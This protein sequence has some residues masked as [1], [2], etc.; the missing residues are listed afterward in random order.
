M[1]KR[2]CVNCESEDVDYSSK[3]VNGNWF[4]CASCGWGFPETDAAKLYFEDIERLKE[5][6]RE[7]LQDIDLTHKQKTKALWKVSKDFIDTLPYGW[8]NNDW[9]KRF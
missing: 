7:Y 5:G 4:L 2:L 9:D 1:I 6:L 8:N 3:S